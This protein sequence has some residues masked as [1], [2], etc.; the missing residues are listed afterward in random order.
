[1][2]ID[3]KRTEDILGYLGKHRKDGQF[4]CGFAMET[5]DLIKNATGKL[6]RKNVDMICANSLRTAGAGF[7]GDTNILTL[8]TEDGCRELP[9][10]SKEEASDMIFDE[11]ME[12]RRHSIR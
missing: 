4:L 7:Q 9:I 10:M 11:I 5:S 2:S 3:L 6:H 12:R 1:M 8:I